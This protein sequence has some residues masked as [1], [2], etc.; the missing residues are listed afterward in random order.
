MGI[1][2]NIAEALQNRAEYNPFLLYC[3]DHRENVREKGSRVKGMC[4]LSSMWKAL[5]EEEKQ[6]YVDMARQNKA[7]DMKQN[8]N[9]MNDQDLGNNGH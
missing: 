7:K 1:I 2:I 8:E 4:T 9:H 5:G 3:K 6:K